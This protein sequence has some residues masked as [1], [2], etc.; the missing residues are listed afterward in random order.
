MSDL[1]ELAR[2]TD[3]HLRAQV[4]LLPAAAVM[5]EGRRRIWRRRALSLA[6]AAVGSLVAAALMPAWWQ[7]AQP[8]PA[9]GWRLDSSI[10]LDDGALILD[11]P[12]SERPRISEAQARG[13]VRQIVSHDLGDPQRLLVARVHANVPPDPDSKQRSAVA[14]TWPLA[15]VELYKPP[16]LTVAAACPPSVADGTPA[17]RPT[18][19]TDQNALII[20]AD[21]GAATI[22]Q[23]YGV[24]TCPPA[25]APDLMPANA[26]FSVPFEE[27]PDGWYLIYLPPCG[28]LDLMMQG[29]A[30]GQQFDLADGELE[31]RVTVPIGPCGQPSPTTQRLHM[32][33]WR[34]PV[35]HAPVGQM[36][37]VGGH[38]VIEPAP[39]GT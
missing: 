9:S 14:G 38:V 18:R 4:H 23:G 13:V 26:T 17:A 1:R 27:Q 37:L 31:I 28:V 36:V 35:I 25:T 12:G 7:S 19:P 24:K 32:P 39:T 34:Q 22:Y 33:D 21:T 20:D 29:P 10:V 30:Q 5:A 8:D 3:M 2:E 11:P 6:A 15:W 16:G